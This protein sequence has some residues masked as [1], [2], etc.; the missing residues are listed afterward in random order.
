MKETS[1]YE[2]ISH[3]IDNCETDAQLDNILSAIEHRFI[4]DEKTKDDLIM[5]WQNN[6]NRRS[7]VT[8]KVAFNKVNKGEF[9]RVDRFPACDEYNEP[10]PSDNSD[11]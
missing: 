3:W 5:Y 6:R 8:A 1:R 7:W 2:I 4:L 9:N 10:Q 11:H